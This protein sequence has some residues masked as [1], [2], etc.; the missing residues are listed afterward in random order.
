[1]RTCVRSALDCRFLVL[2]AGTVFS[3]CT[4]ESSATPVESAPREATEVEA[5][6]APAP[7]GPPP[8]PCASFQNISPQRLAAMLEDKDFLLINTNPPFYAKLAATDKHVPLDSP[9]DW[10][11]RYPTDK[12]AKIVLYCHSGYTSLY[13]A[14][15]L[16]EEGYTRVYNLEGGIAAWEA[17]GLPLV[18]LAGS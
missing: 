2:I 18:R 11:Q 3:G 9:R 6:P 5:G 8:P 17:A 13:A 14:Q 15:T 1:M 7:V 4:W 10:L 12:D 16:Q